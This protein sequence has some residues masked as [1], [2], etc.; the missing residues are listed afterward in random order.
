MDVLEPRH[1]SAHRCA[2][3]FT[4]AFPAALLADDSG[5]ATTIVIAAAAWIVLCLTVSGVLGVT[6]STG[7]TIAAC[8]AVA[9]E[10]LPWASVRE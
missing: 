6:R 3:G 1:R 10:S 5:F 2:V 7:R 4:V 9:N 8:L